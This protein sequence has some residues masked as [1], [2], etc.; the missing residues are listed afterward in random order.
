M[1]SKNYTVN[2]IERRKTQLEQSVARYMDQL[3]NADRE[4]PSEIIALKKTRLN[5]KLAKLKE[6][7]LI[8]PR[9]RNACRPR[10]TSGSRS[11]SPTAD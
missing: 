8:S 2:K 5:E 6:K 1:V 9:S 11:P 3:E 10:L 7:R 4:E